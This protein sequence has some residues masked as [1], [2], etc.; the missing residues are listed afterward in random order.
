MPAA[1]FAIQQ[2]ED[3]SQRIAKL[4][5][6]AG[7]AAQIIAN[8]DSLQKVIEKLSKEDEEKL[9]K[10]Y[11]DDDFKVSTHDAWSRQSTEDAIQSVCTFSRQTTSDDSWVSEDFGQEEHNAL[12]EP[13]DDLDK[14]RL[15][16]YNLCVKNTFIDEPIPVLR[17]VSSAPG[18][19]ELTSA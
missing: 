5:T 17:K 9:P 10:Q 4:N 11:E 16:E 3:V 18:Y 8:V 7:L 2:G 19:L 12:E 15:S 6:V 1:A 13:G 14:L